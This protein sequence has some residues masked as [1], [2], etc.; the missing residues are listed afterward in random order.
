MNLKWYLLFISTLISSS[1]T[2]NVSS[3]TSSYLMLDDKIRIKEILAP[4]LELRE[5]SE[6]YYAVSG[7]K[8]IKE[9]ISKVAEICEFL[10]K[11][12]NDSLTT[13]QIYY[14]ACTW[15]LLER[16]QPKSLPL[17]SLTKTLTAVLEQENS[18]SELY[19]AINSLVSF[20]QKISDAIVAKLLRI[21][22]TRL[23][24][25]D[26]PL[27]LGYIF[28]IAARLGSVG[29]F[30]FNYIEDAIVQ[31]DEVDDKFLQFEGGLSITS[32]LV[33]GIF[34]L[35]SIL[36]RKP[37][38]TSHQIV[39]LVNYFLSRRTV[40][41]PKGAV[42]FL[43]SINILAT[44][45]FEKPVCIALFEDGTVVSIK[46]PLVRVKVCDLLG[47]SLSSIIN[48]VANTATK[49]GDDTVVINKKTFQST[50]NDKTLF[51]LN[52]M[53]T[54]PEPGFYKIVLSA[55][56]VVNTVS[57]KVLTEV[58][59]DY[60]EIGTA[61][62][63]QT[64]QPKLVN[65]VNYKKLNGKIE[66]DFQ[67]K[68]VIRF[69]LKDALKN[70]PIKVHQAFVRLSSLPLKKKNREIIF[71]AEVDASYVYK[72]DMPVG[73]AAKNFD[74]QSGVYSIELIVGDAVVSNSFQWNL[75]AVNLKF[76]E[77]ISSEVV[78]KSTYKREPDI[79]LPKPE[80]KHMFREPEK[81]PPAFVSNLF[82]ALCLSPILLLIILWA[83]LEVNISNFPFSLNAIVF[84]LGLGSIFVLFG[85]FWL[86]LN[87]F[88]TLRY[89]FGLG[90]ITLLSGNK[91]LSQI[92]HNRKTSG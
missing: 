32:H 66:A 69:L 11:S 79:Y 23:K 72:F 18:V 51:T 30:A 45:E 84:H 75:A 39:K 25:D 82:T 28:H 20:G 58:K 60:L 71:V 52:F 38:L 49:I 17:S 64:T 91:L 54:L 7:Y 42:N 67:Q 4:G 59:V 1:V 19:Y 10:I 90:L 48:V 74:Y 55:A 22:Q 12:S 86:K 87:M 43:S 13:E 33:N 21:L 47:N 80:I 56:S 29:N 9:T 70:K 14:L 50:P 57:I 62:A 34:K 68:L 3:S 73:T 46:Q 24:K 65:V 31:A 88:T 92:A 78:E 61:D 35:S 63:D 36:K 81:R 85:V 44:N 53:D 40:Q 27:N 76:P 26:S 6:V 15:K 8:H 83:K 37:P 16:C 2:L 5:L 77:L 89:L 41:T